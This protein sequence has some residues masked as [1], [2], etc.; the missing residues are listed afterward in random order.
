M[1]LKGAPVKT[2]PARPLSV[3]RATRVPATVSAGRVGWAFR[4][5]SRMAATIIDRDVAC[6]SWSIGVAEASIA[7]CG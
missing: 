7:V 4:L 1:R 6:M 2:G 5:D 3:D